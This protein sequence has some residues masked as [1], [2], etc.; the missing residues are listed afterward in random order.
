M[1]NHHSGI[2]P[3]APYT[4]HHVPSPAGMYTQYN[5]GIGNDCKIPIDINKTY[6]VVICLI[7]ELANKKLINTKNILE[8][9]EKRQ[10]VARTIVVQ[11]EDLVD[12]LVEGM[13]DTDKIMYKLDKEP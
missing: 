10:S 5:D 12:A 8:Q 7:E 1:A 13:L 9:L 11:F 3:N 2:L 4:P 6:N